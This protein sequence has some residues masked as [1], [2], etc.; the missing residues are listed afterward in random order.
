MIKKCNAVCSWIL[1]LFLAGHFI[2]M[3][4]SM[5]TG[6]YDYAI[7]KMLARGTAAVAVLHIVISMVILLFLNE[8][9]DLGKYP[10]RNLRVI[11]QRASGLVI[12]ALLHLHVK[13]F[14]FIVQG[15]ALSG[16]EKLWIFLTEF[17]FFAAIFLHLGVSFSRSL[18]TMGWL[19]S[20]TLE[21]RIDR[22]IWI[23]CGLCFAG[24]AASLL[25]FLLGWMS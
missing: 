8:G 2:S 13:A 1:T 11:L 5:L 18:I 6:W 12:I 21:R 24:T 25:Q 19:S 9:T 23:L 20:D 4:Y 14:G 22:G 15:A 16:S 10:R 3:S 17:L 7:C